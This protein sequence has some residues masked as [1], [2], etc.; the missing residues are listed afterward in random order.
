MEGGDDNLTNILNR[1][2]EVTQS[3]VAEFHD[4][5]G[6]GE[7]T[8]GIEEE[9]EALLE[10]AKAN[11]L[12][13]ETFLAEVEGLQMPGDVMEAATPGPQEAVEE[14]EGVFLPVEAASSDEYETAESVNAYDGYD[15][16]ATQPFFESGVVGEFVIG[17]VSKKRSFVP[18]AEERNKKS[19]AEMK[20][21]S[22]S[23]Q[24]T[25]PNS[26]SG[27]SG[28]KSRVCGFNG[29]KKPPGK[30]QTRCHYHR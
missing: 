24:T 17:G 27:G 30:G 14:E 28:D 2:C 13:V 7:W 9:A 10:S 6:A 11:K 29:C 26:S 8:N 3:K 22:V 1:F 15:T 16:E 18:P 12:K 20:S 19:R 4:K 25:S 23:P 21:P 5:A